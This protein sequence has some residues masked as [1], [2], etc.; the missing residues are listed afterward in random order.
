MTV[1]LGALSLALVLCFPQLFHN[2]STL[3]HD[4]FTIV[5]IEF[6]VQTGMFHDCSTF[7]HDCSTIAPISF[8][9]PKT[10]FLFCHYCPTI[11]PPCSRIIPRLLQSRFQ[12]KSNVFCCSTNAV[13]WLHDDY[14]NS[15]T[16]PIS[17][18]VQQTMVF[19]CFRIVPVP[20]ACESDVPHKLG[21]LE[22]TAGRGVR[23]LEGAFTAAST[24]ARCV[25]LFSP[26]RHLYLH[27]PSVCFLTF[28]ALENIIL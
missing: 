16:A 18:S 2:C 28:L 22:L 26:R 9:V 8:S 4:C 11:V 14:A 3:V 15:K 19:W 13:I 7:F 24:C 1:V 20:A 10:V 27:A 17:V 25:L 12:Y 23:N 6:S 21:A 5:P